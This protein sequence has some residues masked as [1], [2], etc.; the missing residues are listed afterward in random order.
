MDEAAEK[1]KN[2]VISQ[3]K[4]SAKGTP[5]IDVIADGCYGKRSYKI[6]YSAL[7]GAGAIIGKKTGAILY[8][9]VIINIAT[10][11][12]AQKKKETTNQSPSMFGFI[13]MHGDRY[14]RRRV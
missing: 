14:H 13:D 2:M 5:I 6:N 12:I 8:L 4:V 11:A 1:E 3:G 10:P 7:S 9:G